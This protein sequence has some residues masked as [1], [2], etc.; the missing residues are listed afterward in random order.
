M[1]AKNDIDYT[2]I[3]FYDFIKSPLAYLDYNSIIWIH[4]QGKN[5]YG[6][7][8]LFCGFDIETYT[9]KDHYA[10]MYIWQFSI[11]GKENFIVYGRTWSEFQT[12]INTL[13]EYLHL[14]EERRLLVGVANLS[15]EHQFMKQWFEWGYCFARE[16]R[17]PIVASLENNTIEFRDVLMITGGSLKQLAKE[18]TITQ[19]VSG[20]DLGYDIPRNYKTKL[21]D[22]ELNY[23][24]KD[25]AIV[26]EFMYYLFETYIKTDH[27]VP[28]TKTGLLRRKVKKAMGKNYDIKREIYRCFPADF[29]F[30]TLLMQWAFRGGYTHGNVRHMGRKIYGFKSRDI[31]SSYPYV[32][33]CYN[34]F[35]NSPLQ[36]RLVSDFEKVIRDDSLCVIFQAT[37]HNIRCITDHAIES[38]SKCKDIVGGIIDNGRVRTAKILTVW[39]TEL[40]YFIYKRFYTWDGKDSEY[41]N[42]IEIGFIYTAVKG[43]LPKYLRKPLAEAY[44]KKA[45]M[46]H[47]GLSGTPE[48]ALYKSLVNSAYGMCVTRLQTK[49]IKLSKIFKEWYADDSSFNYEQEKKKA[50]LLAQW[51][52]YVTAYAR[53]RLLMCVADLGSDAIYCDTD[54]IKYFG[55]HEKYF[56]NI[57]KWT[58]KQTRALCNE[59]NLDYHYFYD[60][61]SFESEYNGKAVDGKFMGAKRYIITTPDG[62]NHVTIAG[63]P[64]DTLPKYCEKMGLDIYDIFHDGLLL[65][66][67]VSLKN[68]VTYNDRPHYDIIDG[69]QCFEKS[70]VGIYPN[71]FT[72]KLQDYYMYL[73]NN[74]ESE[75][76][77]YERR[78]Y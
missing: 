2:A 57:N 32:M 55:D 38:K 59:L 22:K 3:T 35:P 37:F 9:T 78:I 40:D 20:E 74:Y 17:K 65:D 44:L 46:K 21:T 45:E 30:Y 47:N 1:L 52:I 4:K 33:L 19:K 16:K 77:N 36:P 41:N 29:D 42:G 31:T 27:Y 14:S 67:D 34:G 6:Y 54:S 56:E 12:F 48:Y 68:A 11:Y 49:E 76:E 50:F 71:T 72:M 7:V 43:K 62:K 15:Y 39:L 25:V 53:Y 18:Y 28:M 26:S 66:V 13:I 75:V 61:G 58:E 69:V 70:S 23:C 63:L 24:L 64:K 10:Y 60:L 73:I 5:K 51:G 8:E